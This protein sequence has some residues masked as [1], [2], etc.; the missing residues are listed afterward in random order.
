MI[1]PRI[2][3]CVQ[4]PQMSYKSSILKICHILSHNVEIFYIFS[5]CEQ[6]FLDPIYVT[7]SLKDVFTQYG[8]ITNIPMT[9]S[10]F[11]AYRNAHKCHR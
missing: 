2:Y 1:D 6:V 11:A 4:G 3:Y 7:Q 5:A 10:L 9:P 8:S